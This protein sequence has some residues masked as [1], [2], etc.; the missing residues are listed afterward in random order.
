MLLMPLSP[1]SWALLPMTSAC[2]AGKPGTAMSCSPGLEEAGRK[3]VSAMSLRAAL[4]SYTRHDE[5][6]AICCF[7]IC[8]GKVQGR[9]IDNPNLGNGDDKR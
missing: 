7:A 4:P 2:Y 3:R 6:W 8:V 5:G 9:D 1:S